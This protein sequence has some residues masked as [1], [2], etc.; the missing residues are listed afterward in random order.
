MN[1]STPRKG[2][3][4]Q[5]LWQLRKRAE[6][7]CTRCGAL[8]DGKSKDYCDKCR[9]RHNAYVRSG[10]AKRKARR[11]IERDILNHAVPHPEAG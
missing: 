3:S 2:V 4:R 7:R 11:A 9:K 8:R 1:D 6:G 10:Y 5:R